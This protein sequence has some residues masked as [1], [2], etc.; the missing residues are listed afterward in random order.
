MFAINPLAI[1]SIV[2]ATAI[3]AAGGWVVQGWR[4]ESKYQ[5]EAVEREQS[6][7]REIMAHIRNNERKEEENKSNSARIAKVN[8]DEMDKMHAALAAAK[9]RVPK[10]CNRPTEGAKADSPYSRDAADT[11]AR[12]FP[13]EVERN[14]RALIEE[15]EKAAATG[16]AAQEFI[17]S[18]G[19][20]PE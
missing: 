12:L 18:N 15:T 13:A 20:A 8:K 1:G 11:S 3:G 7:N 17:R 19:F 5:A 9:L 4:L 10:W 6:A 2:V 14:I 16:R